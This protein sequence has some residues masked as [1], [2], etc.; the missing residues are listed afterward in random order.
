[1]P[2]CRHL[3]TKLPLGS[4]RVSLGMMSRWED[5]Y[6]LVNFIRD[7][8]TDLKAEDLPPVRDQPPSHLYPGWC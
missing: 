7:N 3:L 4:I 5:A 6:A 2:G 1:M 8:Y